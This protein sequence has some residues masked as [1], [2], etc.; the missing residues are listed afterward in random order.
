MKKNIILICLFLAATAQAQ[1]LQV[2]Q[3]VKLSTPIDPMA[4]QVAAISPH[5]DYVLLCSQEQDGLMKFDLATGESKVLT[6]ARGAGFSTKISHDGNDVVYQEVTVA[7]D[8][9]LRRSVKT[10]DLRTSMV[11]TIAPPT[12]ELQGFDMPD[13]FVAAVVS[14]EV[15]SPGID[16]TAIVRPI[17]SNRNLKLVLTTGGVTR[18]F[19]PNGNQYN[20]IWASISPSGK[21]VLY[22]VSELGC[23]TCNLDGSDMVKLGELRAPQWLDDNTVVGMRDHDDGITITSSTIVA[24]TLD[25]TEQTLTSDDMIALFPQ[26]ASRAGKIAFSTMQGEIYIINF[27]K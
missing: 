21:R 4:R 17:V 27:T 10:I 9:L 22:Y 12:R 25:G 1:V 16:P 18:Q 7:P 23:F 5:G 15:K 20:Y 13:G 3:V 6:T 24:K 8:H 19:T 11:K 26:V 2:Q 14:D